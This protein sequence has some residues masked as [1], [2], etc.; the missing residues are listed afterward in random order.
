MREIKILPCF[1]ASVLPMTD[2]SDYLRAYFIGVNGT[3]SSLKNFIPPAS[4]HML[5]HISG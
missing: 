5:A 1:N 4:F 2:I 3:I